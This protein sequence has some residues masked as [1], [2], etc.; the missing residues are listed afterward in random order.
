MTM[1]SGILHPYHLDE[2]ISSV[3]GLLSMF[4]SVMYFE[5]N[6]NSFVINTADPD[7]MQHSEASELGLHCLYVSQ[8]SRD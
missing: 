3:M 4:L 2:S 7:Q 1:T 5:L 8:N 6:S